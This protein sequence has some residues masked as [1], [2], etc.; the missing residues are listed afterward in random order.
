M[1]RTVPCFTAFFE[2][3]RVGECIVE[4][5]VG[6]GIEVCKVHGFLKFRG[7]R[8]FIFFSHTYIGNNG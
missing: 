2:K 7:F 3:R 1:S 6:I 4:V 8:P 5:I